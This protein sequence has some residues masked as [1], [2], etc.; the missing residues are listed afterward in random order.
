MPTMVR[1]YFRSIVFLIG[2]AAAMF[3]AQHASGQA[4][5]ADSTTGFAPLDQWKNAVV[6]GDAAALKASYSTDPEAQVMANGITVNEG[7]PISN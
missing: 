1:G 2:I 7:P 6:A 5:M 3:A 4:S